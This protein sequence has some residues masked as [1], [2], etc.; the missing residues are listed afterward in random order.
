MTSEQHEG[1]YGWFPGSFCFL[2]SV[3]LAVFSQQL[4]F[5]RFN[6]GTENSDRQHWKHGASGVRFIN[7]SDSI[8]APQSSGSLDDFGGGCV[9]KPGVC[10][11]SH[12]CWA[13]FFVLVRLEPEP[14]WNF[15]I[16]ELEHW[17]L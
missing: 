15:E 8:F 16:L 12:S 9:W 7:G 11:G 1:N 2:G 6:S 3:R 10:V 4:G 13:L 14:P 5:G 17:S